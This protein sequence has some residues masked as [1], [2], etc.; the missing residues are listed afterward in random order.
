[1]API[2]Q[3][4]V[5]Q[6]RRATKYVRSRLSGQTLTLTM[7]VVADRNL[8]GKLV[9]TALLAALP[10]ISDTTVDLEQ[11]AQQLNRK[12]LGGK[13]SWESIKWVSNMTGRWGSCTAASAQHG[14]RIRIS[15]VLKSV[16]AYVL[17]AVVLHEVA[18][19]I[20]ANH[21]PEFQ[22]L[23]QAFPQL[24]R[25]EGFLECYSRYRDLPAVAAA[26]EPTQVLLVRIGPNGEELEEFPVDLTQLAPRQSAYPP[27]TKSRR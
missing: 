7:P 20:Q 23:L 11:L 25:A 19:T 8:E 6:S 9:N 5:K 17:Q 14:A 15:D 22:R 21:G 4:Q 2:A 3:I 16:P 26:S 27:Q 13:G 10:R 12:F 18:H 1:M 24:A